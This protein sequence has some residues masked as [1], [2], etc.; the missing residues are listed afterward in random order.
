MV[1]VVPSVA[2]FNRALASLSSSGPRSFAA[3]KDDGSV[4]TWGDPN[5]GGDS[6]AV[7]SQL[8]FGVSQIFSSGSFAALKDDGSVVTWG[9]P[10]SGGDSSAVT[11]QLE[12]GSKSFHWEGLC[13]AQMR[14]CRYLG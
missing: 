6:S 8:E 10:N 3:L 12:S 5:T 14:V 13:G 4:V 1:I 7:S 9:N 11:S 2:I